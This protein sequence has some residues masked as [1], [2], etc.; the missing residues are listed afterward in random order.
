MNKVDGADPSERSER[1]PT[2]ENNKSTMFFIEFPKVL[3]IDLGI[4]NLGQLTYID[5]K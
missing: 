5:G 3:G 1:T 2:P 4:L